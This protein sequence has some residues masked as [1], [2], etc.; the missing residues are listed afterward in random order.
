MKTTWWKILIVVALASVVAV[1]VATKNRPTDMGATPQQGTAPALEA[2]KGGEVAADST[3]AMK[4]PRLLDL[5][6]KKCIPCK[7]MVP[8]LEELATEY[9]GRLE[10]GFIDVWENPD[11]AEKLGIQSI[12][13]QIFYSADG[14]ELFRHEGFYSKVDILAKFKEKGM[15]F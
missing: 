8:V 13:T 4:L 11:A 7:L 14:E 15:T 2:A 5:G 1:V 9:K 6:A 12:P 3:P 10:V